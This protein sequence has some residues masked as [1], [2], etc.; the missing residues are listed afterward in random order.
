[1]GGNG[2]G[3]DKIYGNGNGNKIMGMGGN[4]NS[5]CYSCTPLIRWMALLW[6]TKSEGVG[7]IGRLVSKI[8]D[9]QPM[10]S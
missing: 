10:W 8:K 6:A 1:M 7:L 5:K 3:N 9:F 2:N 4:G